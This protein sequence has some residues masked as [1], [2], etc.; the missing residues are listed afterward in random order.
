[1]NDLAML[2]I[3]YDP[4]EDVWDVFFRC[5]NDNWKSR[6]KTY[7]ITNEVTPCYENTIVIAA[8]K[9]AEWSKKVQV[10]LKAISENY[11]C[12]LLEDFFIAD[13]VSNNTIAM[14]MNTIITNN[15]NYYKLQDQKKI[16]G[17]LF[18]KKNKIHFIDKNEKYGISLQPA[19]WEKKFLSELV[20]TNNYNAW[21]FEFNQVKNET[22]KRADVVC[23]GDNENRLNIIHAVVQ[24]EYLRNAILEMKKRGYILDLNSRQ[25]M[26][27]KKYYAYRMKQFFSWYTPA[28][29]FSTVRKIGELFGLEYISDRELGGK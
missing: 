16:K 12:L 22:H 4:Y 29:L 19:I 10:G 28:F 20:G 15:V 9:D 8:G 5:I 13:V 7:L 25:K 17:P 18:D 3:G 24:Q 26:K 23:L 6:P 21:I 11:V 1:M 27:L 2:I 14:L